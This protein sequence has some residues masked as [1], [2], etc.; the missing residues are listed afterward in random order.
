[1]PSVRIKRG[2]TLL[3]HGP[4]S[5]LLVEGQASVLGCPLSSRRRLIVRGWRSRPIYAEKNSV[6][7]IAYGENGGYELIEGDAVPEEWR[8]F[9]EK[10]S[11]RSPR[12]CVYGG[13][14]SGKTTLAT[15]LVNALVKRN[16]L[17]VY[18]DLDLGQSNICPPTTIGYAAIRSPIPDV[19]YLR[20]ELGEVAGY[21]SP[22]PLIE[23]HLQAVKKLAEN[24]LKSYPEASISMDLDGWVSGEQ[25]VKHKE[26]MLEILK[27][28]FLALI[29]D[30]PEEIKKTCEKLGILYEQLPPPRNIRRRDQSAR[31][32]LREIAYE[33][34]LRKS[35][36]RKIPASWI[37]MKTI[38]D[39]S[40]PN[41]VKEHAKALIQAYAENSGEIFD[42]DVAEALEELAK[43]RI[44]ILSYLRDLTGR[45][46]GISLLVGLDLRRNFV[47]I[48]T[49]YQAQIKEIILGAILLSADGEEIYSDPKIFSLNRMG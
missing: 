28:N 29:G 47:K 8:A 6:I 40:G 23:K 24:L 18:L 26:R 10:I 13:A 22:T 21:T 32:R 17:S 19:S 33:R 43:R 45:F 20:M 38:T 37:E 15:L 9:A 2:N 34:F 39:R 30:S 14:D 48:L 16:G 49:P 36:V 7:D 25:A 42:R 12:V 46:V 31:K 35:V 11:K 3:L 44:G 41:E 1:M 27:P 4:A 5:A